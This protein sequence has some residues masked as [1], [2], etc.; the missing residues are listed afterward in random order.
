M[1]ATGFYLD[2]ARVGGF[3]VKF[4]VQKKDR[5]G[6]LLAYVYLP[7]CF[8]NDDEPPCELNMVMGDEYVELRGGKKDNGIYI[9]LNATIIKSGYATPTRI[10]PNEKHAD[11][12][13]KLYEEAR[14]AKRGMFK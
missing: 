12:F 3:L 7:Q 8:W 10:P 6:R 4:D 11:I 5:Y 9:F 1:M 14:E 2:L 13:Q